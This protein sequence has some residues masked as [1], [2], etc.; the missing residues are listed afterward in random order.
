MPSSW[1][2]QAY[3][4]LHQPLTLMKLMSM[5]NYMEDMMEPFGDLTMKLFGTTSSLSAT[6]LLF[7]KPFAPLSA[8]RMEGP[9][10]WL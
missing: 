2:L 6:R 8:G 4:W 5:W 7:G 3:L 1:M 9:P 10:G